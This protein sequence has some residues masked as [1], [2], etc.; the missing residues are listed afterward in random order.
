MI[1]S[2][3]KQ[4]AGPRQAHIVFEWFEVIRR[5]VRARS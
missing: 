4:E 5:R 2:G 1:K 3:G